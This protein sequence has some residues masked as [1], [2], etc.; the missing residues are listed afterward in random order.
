VSYERKLLLFIK[1]WRDNILVIMPDALNFSLG[2]S[3]FA[4]E[5]YDGMNV[6]E[7]VQAVAALPMDAVY[8][9]K[10][11]LEVPEGADQVVR[12]LGNGALTY[13]TKRREIAFVEEVPPRKVRLTRLEGRLLELLTRTP[14]QVIE[15]HYA[16]QH[17]SGYAQKGGS[18]RVH[19]SSLREKLGN[20]RGLLQ[21]LHGIGIVFNNP[22]S[23]L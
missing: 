15:H 12:T 17:M 7:V 1:S 16:I 18:T 14:G 2:K 3:S 10:T 13:D 20:Q 9:G 23:E 21:T 5:L 11:D 4:V 6:F 19:L 22:D 8:G